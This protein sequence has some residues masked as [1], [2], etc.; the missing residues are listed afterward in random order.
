MFDV[1]KSVARHFFVYGFGRILNRIVGFLLIPLYTHY[2]LPSDY[3][4]LEMIEVTVYLVGTF[5]GAGLTHAVMRFYFESEEASYRQTV[6]ST[7]L[8]SVLLICFVLGGSLAV[9]SPAVSTLV[10][11]SQEYGGLLRLAVITLTATVVSETPLV[12]LRAR[13]KSVLYTVSSVLRLAVNLSLNILFI[14]KYGMGVRGVI[15]GGLISEVCLGLAL[16]AYTLKHV[17]ISFSRPR[18]KE[19]LRYGIPYIPGGFVIS[20]LLVADRFALQRFTNLTEVGLYALGYKFGLVMGAMVTE[21]FFLIWRPKM[22][23]VAKRED[24]SQIYGRMLT[25]FLFLELFVALGIS[26]GVKDVVTIMA[27]PKYHSAYQ[28]T[29]FIVLAYVM[30]G[31]YN[32]AQVGILLAKKTKYILYI[33]IVGAI[34]GI[35][36]NVALVPWL[37]AWGAATATLSA[38][39]LLTVMAYRI[40][41]RFVHVDFEFGRIGKM[42][43]VAL[44][45][46]G[47]SLL[48]EVSSSTYLNLAVRLLIATTFPFA[49]VL[50]R[51][52]EPEEVGKIRELSASAWL[53]MRSRTRW[54]ETSP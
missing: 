53:L 3:G 15:L 48:M 31:V 38:W 49:L 16:T 8:L 4:T 44:V 37:G 18:L 25:Y 43:T 7:A 28:I 17:G 5:L 19:M 29:P 46:Y 24:A 26:A 6:V 12:F 23:E 35:V 32:H 45:L 10:F 51:F 14:V 2:L 39:T 42:L 1:V 36:L 22:F 21:P 41:Q 33:Q 47:I 27:D 20:I 30:G 34:A 52:Y 54:R 50:V 9:I 40:S 11:Q 13:E